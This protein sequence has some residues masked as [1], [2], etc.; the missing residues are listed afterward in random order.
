MSK[1][2]P[3]KKKV[4]LISVNKEAFTNAVNSYISTNLDS[5]FKFV[6]SDIQFKEVTSSGNLVIGVTGTLKLNRK[7]INIDEDFHIYSDQINE[8]DECVVEFLASHL[9]LHQG[10]DKLIPEALMAGFGIN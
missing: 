3:T 7:N 2:R 5:S 1:K 4:S 6:C 8:I 10:N 9:G